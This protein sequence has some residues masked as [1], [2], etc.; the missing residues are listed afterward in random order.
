MAKLP[1]Q[2]GPQGELMI[3]MLGTFSQFERALILQRTARGRRYK[4]ESLGLILGNIPPYGFDYIK[5]DRHAGTMGRYVVNPAEAG[6][7]KQMFQW[8]VEEG[9]TGRGVQRRLNGLG[10]TSRSG[11]PWGKSSVMR[12]LTNETYCGTTYYNKHKTAYREDCQRGS[13]TCTRRPRDEWVPIDLPSELHLISRDLFA[14]AQTQIRKNRSMP[15]EHRK[16]RYLL[17]RID[18]RCAHCGSTYAG[19]SSRGTR[20]YRCQGSRTAPRCVAGSVRADAIEPAVWSVVERKL[21]D[22]EVMQRLLDDV[23]AAG[24]DTGGSDASTVRD[25]IRARRDTI[26]RARDRLLRAYQQ[27][28]VSEREL[29]GHGADL[30]RELE[31]LEQ[32]LELS[33]RAAGECVQPPPGPKSLE[34]WTASVRRRLASAS[35]STCEMVLADL[36]EGVVFDVPSQRVLVR[37]IAPHGTT[38]G[39]SSSG[40]SS[41]TLRSIASTSGYQ[42]GRAPDRVESMPGYQRGRDPERVE[43]MQRHQHRHELP[44]QSHCLG[45]WVAIQ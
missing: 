12:V 25:G 26:Q 35:A 6:I 38:G 41:R 42:R 2:Q 5:R 34:E 27:G 14:R 3:N 18:R 30:R 11:G 20:Y 1:H 10:I 31:E 43:S 13:R 19:E 32:Q 4:T 40:R 9:L 36:L 17:K 7:V 39:R 16:M 37:V 21:T 28:L 24:A 33:Q 23:A 29:R 15:P 45:I 8:L 44:L 22:P